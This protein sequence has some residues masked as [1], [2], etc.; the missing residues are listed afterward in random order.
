MSSIGRK[1]RSHSIGIQ[2]SEESVHDSACES[3]SDDIGLASDSADNQAIHADENPEAAGQ[4]AVALRNAPEFVIVDSREEENGTPASRDEVMEFDRKEEK[5]GSAI[6]EKDPERE[7]D[8]VTSDEYGE[9]GG[10]AISGNEGMRND[11]PPLE[12]IGND[13][14]DFLK[15][16]SD[17]TLATLF[18]PRLDLS[19]YKSPSVDLLEDYSNMIYTV[20]QAELEKNNRKI[21]KTLANYGISVD[22]VTARIGPTVTLYEIV[23]SAGV[24]VSQIKRLEDDIALWLAAKG[25]RIVTLT[26]AVGIEVANERPSIVPLKS[27]LNDDAFRENKFELPVAIGYAITQNVKVFDLA[28]APHLLVAGATKQGKSVGLNVIITSL[29]YARHP[30]ELKFVF[31]DPKMVEFNA[32]SKLLKHYLAVLPTAADEQDEMSSA[33]VKNPKQAETIL[34][35]LCKEMDERYKLMSVTSANNVKL[36]NEKYKDRRLNPNDGH[37]FLPYIVVVIDEYADLIMSVS[38][39]SEAKTQARNIT[40]SIIRLAQKGRAAGIH[41]II[42]TQRPSVDVVTGII[43]TNFPMRIAFRTSTRVDSNTILDTPGAE[44]L[45]GKGDMLYYA[46]VEIERVQCAMISMDEIY[47]VTDYIG[48]QTGYKQCYNT[49]YY[50]PEPETAAQENAPGEVDMQNLDENFKD[51][52]EYVVR[53]QKGSTSDLQRSLGMGYA[54]AGR[55]MDQLEA[56]GIVGPQEGS[57]P[58][59]VLVSDLDELQGILDAYMNG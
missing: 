16:L 28:E 20:P 31:I 21:V 23:P 42:A 5:G 55:V 10:E 9:A 12:V 13:D 59:Q 22:K 17:D 7:D 53:R 6:P 25:V 34:Q 8:G 51:A 2:G 30:S 46:G 57:K 50:L 14:E 49:P 45:I 41:V 27:C 24:R 35:S 3:Q 36:Y 19:S 43:K 52:A 32:Y 33:I 44:K 54:R 58:R 15:T 48:A 18:D 40:T 56:A 39:G 47:R 1:R 26:N 11:V 4:N 37:R 38:S 29:L